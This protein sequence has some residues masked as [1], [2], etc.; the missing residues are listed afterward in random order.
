MIGWTSD[1][2]F[3]SD[4]FGIHLY[5]PTQFT[6]GDLGSV[7]LEPL[8]RGA[9]QNIESRK[10]VSWCQTQGAKAI[11]ASEDP[12]SQWAPCRSAIGRYGHICSRLVDFATSLN[13]S[14][15]LAY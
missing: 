10:Y 5:M 3:V 9:N 13:V 1:E 14:L 6:S 12:N 11:N 15:K 8:K 2:P 7:R 4:M